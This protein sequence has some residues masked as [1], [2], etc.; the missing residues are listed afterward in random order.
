MWNIYI[1]SKCK[2]K[3]IENIT[4]TRTQSRNRKLSVPQKLHCPHFYSHDL[5]TQYRVYW[6]I[7]TLTEEGK[8]KKGKERREG[9]GGGARR[10][11]GGKKKQRRDG[12]G[13]KATQGKCSSLSSVVSL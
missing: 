5:L 13:D 1:I 4:V 9:E 2:K 12:G 10:G 6:K 11:K 3:Q 8:D 7:C